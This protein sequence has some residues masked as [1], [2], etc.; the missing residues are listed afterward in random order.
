MTMGT[1]ILE[2]H[3]LVNI[4]NVLKKIDS[5]ME[6]QAKRLD[7]LE[8]STISPSSSNSNRS[9]DTTFS[10]EPSL[11]R[12]QTV[13]T[14]TSTERT[15]VDL[16]AEDSEDIKYVHSVLKIKQFLDEAASLE[17]QEYLDE[18][19]VPEEPKNQNFEATGTWADLLC[20]RTPDIDH[21]SMS[22]Y[23]GDVLQ[24]S[25]MS[26]TLS[27]HID[28][29][30]RPPNQQVPPS[31]EASESEAKTEE[32]AQSVIAQQIDALHD[33]NELHVTGE[34]A[35]DSNIE[36]VNTG[37]DSQANTPRRRISINITETKTRPSYI[38]VE[39]A[40]YAFDS[41]K[42][43]VIC[44]VKNN[45]REL[46]GQGKIKMDSLRKSTHQAK[47]QVEKGLVKVRS[48]LEKKPNEENERLRSLHELGMNKG[49]RVFRWRITISFRN[50]A[51]N[52]EQEKS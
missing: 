17:N 18:I 15:T 13:R 47:E 30:L 8:T 25:R 28:H 37:P 32:D 33:M 38:R 7:V 48:A 14:S 29:N 11:S 1:D 52:K 9:G 35:M 39:L 3:V 49:L 23:S 20:P 22:M 36:D 26:L 21:Y 4:L 34:N 43:D 42:Q 12:G 10:S 16:E 6:L 41:W 51:N 2:S 19:A 45:S 5:K 40:F 50:V 31:P 44:R 27:Q 24:S 46:W